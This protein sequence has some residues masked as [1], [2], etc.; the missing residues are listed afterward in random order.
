MPRKTV[1]ELAEILEQI[2][3]EYTD[4][5]FD[6]TGDNT[7]DKQNWAALHLGFMAAIKVLGYTEFEAHEVLEKAQ[8][9]ISNWSVNKK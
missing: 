7:M 5:Y 4:V 2:T 8:D 6:A 9:K 1:E 3:I